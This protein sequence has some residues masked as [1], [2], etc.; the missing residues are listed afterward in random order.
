MENTKTKATAFDQGYSI[1]VNRFVPRERVRDFGW[2]SI[3]WSA[4]MISIIKRD[5]AETQTVTELSA[6]QAVKGAVSGECRACAS[7]K[8]K[9]NGTPAMVFTVFLNTNL[10]TFLQ[11]AQSVSERVNTER[12][13]LTY[14]RLCFHYLTS[15]NFSLFWILYHFNPSFP[16]C[17]RVPYV[18]Q[19]KIRKN[20]W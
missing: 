19:L 1:T 3:L 15:T 4:H 9:R 12:E 20:E 8:R 18:I 11:S 5:R 7:F 2:E 14:F 13:C 6:L 16:S 10:L 17:H